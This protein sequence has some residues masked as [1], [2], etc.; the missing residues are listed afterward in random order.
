MH[1]AEC[2]YA[3]C[4]H[5]KCHFAKCHSATFKN[6]KCYYTDK[7]LNV[8]INCV[9]LLNVIIQNISVLSYISAECYSTEFHNDNFQSTKCH[10]SERYYA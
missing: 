6:T 1:S 5:V 2:R 9:I 7:M 8:V 3:E 4:H 10:Y